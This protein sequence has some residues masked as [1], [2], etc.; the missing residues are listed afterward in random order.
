MT[1]QEII[2]MFE[3]CCFSIVLA[4]CITFFFWKIFIEKPGRKL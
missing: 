4:F 1:I 2:A 3:A